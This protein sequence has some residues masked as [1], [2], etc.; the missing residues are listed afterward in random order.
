MFLLE[1]GLEKENYKNLGFYNRVCTRSTDYTKNWE[2]QV[3]IIF[4][5]ETL[6]SVY[7]VNRTL[8]SIEWI[9]RFYREELGLE[10]LSQFQN[11]RVPSRHHGHDV[12]RTHWE[13][14]ILD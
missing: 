6:S 4:F 2:N 1:F 13:I 10:F 11:L 9:D 3:S 8:C 12:D 5:C 14:L 7:P